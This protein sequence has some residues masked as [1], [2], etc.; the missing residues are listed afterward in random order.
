MSPS[1]HKRD[2]AAEYARRKARL[3]LTGQTPYSQRKRGT[4]V[5]GPIP[6]SKSQEIEALRKFGVTRTE[7]ERMRQANI[8]YAIPQ[9]TH[10]T[11]PSLEKRKRL[12]FATFVN[13][14]DQ[15]RDIPNDWSDQR[16]GYVVSFYRAIVDPRTNY[17]TLIDKDGQRIKH[18][19]GTYKSNKW[20][21]AYMGHYRDQAPFERYTTNELVKYAN[22]KEL[23][24][25][26]TRYGAITI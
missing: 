14:Y 21:A 11:S 10:R 23:D 13:T 20:Q 4:S 3:A 7:F 26:E 18:K 2:Y 17:Q 16:V 12:N 22:Q 5:F 1:Q 9:F 15:D 8:P 24:E 19:D 6:Q 25:F